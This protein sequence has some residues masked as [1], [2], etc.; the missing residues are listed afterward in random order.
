MP[1]LPLPEPSKKKNRQSCQA[2][3]P[4]CGARTRDVETIHPAMRRL[5]VEGLFSPR[6]NA[7]DE[8]N[9]PDGE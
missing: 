7:A 8:L 6:G 2:D 4:G 1:S 5:F 3:D 9:M